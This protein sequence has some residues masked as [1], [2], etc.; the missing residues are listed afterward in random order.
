M[1][2]EFIAGDSRLIRPAEAALK[3]DFRRGEA[4]RRPFSTGFSRL[5]LT[6]AVVFGAAC[7]GTQADEPDVLSFFRD[8]IEPVLKRE[9]FSCHSGQSTT[10]QAGLRLDTRNHVLRGG[11]SGPAAVL[12]KSGQSLLV[13]AIRHEGGMEMPPKKPKLADSTI[14][15]FE[16]WIDAG[17]PGLPDGIDSLESSSNMAEGRSHWAFQPI[18]KTVPP[19]T[20]DPEWGQQVIDAFVLSKLEERQWK[21]SGPATREELIRRVTFDL[22]GLP[23][24]PEQIQAFIN[25]V[26][27]D[28]YEQLVDRLLNSPRYG[29]RW[30]QHWLDVVRFAET[31]GF[32]YDA[33]IPEA[34]RFRD[35]VINSFNQDKPFDRFLTEQ[36][37]GDEIAPDDTECQTASIFF[38]LGPVRRN[39]GNP[40]IALS[41]NEV[42]TERTD[43][44]GALFL[45]L[46]VG[47]ARCHNHKL[48]P[49]SQKDYY[50]LQAYMAATDEH[51]I[52]LASAAEQERWQE[53]TK[54]T[55]SEIGALRSQISKSEGSEKANLEARIEQLQ[56]TL[57]APLPVVPATRN[58]FEKRTEIHVLRRGI[59][60]NKGEAVGARPLSV[61]INEQVA[62]LAADIANP[63]THLAQ[64]L[65][66]PELPLT[67]R[68]IVNRIWQRHFGAGIVKTPNDFG[69]RGDRPSHPEL[70]DW[71]AATFIEGGWRLKPLHR[72]IVLSKTYQQ[73]NSSISD[74]PQEKLDPE[75]RL[76]WHMERRRLS[77]EEVRDAMLC[78][79]GRINLKMG[80]PSIMVPVEAELINLL[81]KPSQWTVAKDPTEHNRRSIYLIAKRNLRLPFLENFDAPA[82]QTTC[83]RRETSSHAPQALEMLNG[84]FSNQMAVDF[85]QRL[86]R[87]TAGDRNRIVDR[88]FQLALGRSPLPEER[89]RSREFLDEQPLSEFALAIFNVNGF[90]YVP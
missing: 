15:D 60:E 65:V 42:L 71:L 61:L 74:S 85:A 77:A 70:L 64:W 46:T 37:A 59:W 82:L 86:E 13:Q 43:I 14:A 84:S 53:A 39:A 7:P 35:Y 81:Y 36:I 69:V 56:Q 45:G 41:R 34:W 30:A 80:G 27:T 63:R 6:F 20:S 49:I 32:E 52:T 11:E 48:E 79:S 75:N 10:V 38:R 17:L 33:A 87:E 8:K 62:E 58:N 29:E 24:S 72:L 25:D 68:V 31:E 3:P 67:A 83:A 9:C 44:I 12:G 47:C 89:R 51:N 21:P 57:P 1:F 22:T 2:R 54:R 40:E 19:K 5:I 23:P 55:N 78:V 26:R 76:L 50:R 66:S 90:L 18:R 16:K 4:A 73:S 88:A 28:A